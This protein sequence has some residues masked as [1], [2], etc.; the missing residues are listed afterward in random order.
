LYC[1]IYHR[2]LGL[3]LDGSINMNSFTWILSKAFDFSSVLNYILLHT[4]FHSSLTLFTLKLPSLFVSSFGSIWASIWSVKLLFRYFQW[5]KLSELC[6]PL[7]LQLKIQ[8][9]QNR[10]FFI[11]FKWMERKFSSFVSWLQMEISIDW[12]EFNPIS[13]RNWYPIE[14]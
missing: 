14:C 6:W 3:V 11:I 12:V 2:A 9:P 13:E 5:K 4:N 7:Q 1:S 8:E 10:G